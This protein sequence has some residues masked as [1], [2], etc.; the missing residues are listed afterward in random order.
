MDLSLNER[1]EGADRRVV[2]EARIDALAV[3][4]FAV[5]LCAAGAARPSLWF[6][7]AATISAATRSIPQLWDLIGHIDAVHGLYYLGMHGWFAIF[8][9]TEFW[10]RFSSCLAIGGAAAGVVVLGRQF[11]TRTVSVC[12]GIL[13]AM[14]P[15]ITWAGIEARSYSWSTLAAVWLTVLLI[16]AIRRD[17]TAVWLS[18]GALLAG[19]T[20][21]NMFVVLMVVPHAVAVAIVCNRRRT[22]IR[23]ASVTAAAV[24]VV[25]PFVLWCRSQS[26]Q[27]GW[28]SPLGLHSFAE[29]LVN[30][31]FDESVAFAVL[32]AVV[33]SAPL[34]TRRRPTDDGTRRLVAVAVVWVVAPTAVL[35]AYSAVAQPLY[36]PRYLC[37]TTPGMAL[38]LAVCVVAVARSREWVT[39]TLAVFAVAATPNYLT[40]QRGP[41]AKE[42]M[43]FSQVADVISA[44]S[45]PGDCVIFD[46]T[47]SWKPGPIRPI[48][49][50]RPAAYADLIDPGRGRPAWQRNRLWDAHLGIW[51]VA[52]QV[53]RCTVLWTVSERDPAVPS[54][55]SGERLQPGPRL[56]RAPAY[57]VPESMGFHIVERWQFNFA[58]VVKSTR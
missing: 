57:Q 42:G 15:R 9:A 24:V 11:S 58:Q 45:S 25:V 28:I 20:V 17:R 49:A 34:L 10:S 14:L 40:V 12:A 35:L 37:F 1:A 21:L 47:A 54:R 33:L 29:V 32:A 30:Q 27:V 38:L 22:R 52:D 8:P 2:R 56:D 19:S 50:A 16:S 51:G 36:Y 41:Y 7:E 43:D 5:A 53:R 3:A 48:T 39:A 26:F 18:Y 4:A 55:Q 46:N 6:D 31:Y 23:W 44:H 13:F